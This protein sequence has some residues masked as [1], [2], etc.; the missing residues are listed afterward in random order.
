MLNCHLQ[1]K[2]N[3]QTQWQLTQGSCIKKKNLMLQKFAY[4]TQKNH[5]FVGKPNPNPSLKFKDL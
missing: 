3:H 2:K 5:Q 4:I 1:Y